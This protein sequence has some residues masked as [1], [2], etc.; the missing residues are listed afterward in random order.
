M[1]VKMNVEKCDVVIA[2]WGFPFLN[3]MTGLNDGRVTSKQN[4][5]M[6]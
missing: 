5:Q 2:T 6:L 3:H 1:N 4:L